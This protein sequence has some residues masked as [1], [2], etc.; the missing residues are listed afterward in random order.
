[1]PIYTAVGVSKAALESLT[2]YLAIELAPKF[3]AAY[4]SRGYARSKKGEYEKAI[5]DFDKAIDLGRGDPNVA[6]AYMNRGLAYKAL[7]MKT[8][9]IANLVKCIELSQDPSLTRLA[10]GELGELQNQN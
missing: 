5:A 10:E 7:G 4:D 6:G 8:E 2:K 9:A 3:A 1:M